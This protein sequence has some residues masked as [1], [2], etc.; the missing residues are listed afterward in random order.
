MV[1]SS[2]ELAHEVLWNGPGLFQLLSQA[3]RPRLPF[4]DSALFHHHQGTGCVF[5]LDPYAL[6][7][8]EVL[9]RALHHVPRFFH[10]FLVLVH[11]VGSFL[12][13]VVEV[14]LGAVLSHVR[15]NPP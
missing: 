5:V 2:N 12:L 1:K 3:S 15:F 4:T 13:A 6:K 8:S 11:L 7:T 9:L 10:F 14:G